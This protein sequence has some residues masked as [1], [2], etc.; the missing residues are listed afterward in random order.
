MSSG[1]SWQP[2]RGS[3][4]E[5]PGCTGGS[6]EGTCETHVIGGR[7][8]LCVNRL[9]GASVGQGDSGSPVFGKLGPYAI[10]FGIVVAVGPLNKPDLRD[11]SR[12]CEEPPNR[13]HVHTGL[14]AG[15]SNR[16]ATEP[17]HWRASHV[18]STWLKNLG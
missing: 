9:E 10:A 1:R 16:S 18:R 13:R 2:P 4:V 14:C 7:L 17:T 15:R 12:Y 3:S 6:I 5:P 8:N 11:N